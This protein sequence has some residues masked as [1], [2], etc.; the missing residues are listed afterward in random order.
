MRG[1]KYGDISL[2]F[3]IFSFAINVIFFTNSHI[4]GRIA[5]TSDYFM[6]A[7]ALSTFSLFL[8]RDFGS[9]FLVP[10]M[11]VLPFL[12]GDLYKYDEIVKF[13]F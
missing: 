12:F 3:V 11:A 13:L 9:L 10:I 4:A 6:F 7:F 1:K 5:R 2:I 8:N